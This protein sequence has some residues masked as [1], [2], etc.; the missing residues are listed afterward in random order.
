[1]T[2]LATRSI[3]NDASDLSRAIVTL[4]IE[5][6]LIDIG[7]PVYNLILERLE[8]DKTTIPGLYENPV[9]L[10][11]LLEE[12]FGPASEEIMKSIKK[13]LEEFSDKEQIKNFLN[14]LN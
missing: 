12:L 7:K 3:V 6:S 1:M 13:H 8:T 9:Y 11:V 10:K 14:L 5:K 4:S 2:A